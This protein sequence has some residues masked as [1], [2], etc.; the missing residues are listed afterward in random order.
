MLRKKKNGRVKKAGFK[1]TRRLKKR[2]V[3][4]KTGKFKKKLRIGKKKKPGIVRG[5][6]RKGKRAGLKAGR[7]RRRGLKSRRFA[8]RP[9]RA[10]E[11][12][13]DRSGGYDAGFDQGY[14]EGFREGFNKGLED[15]ALEYDQRKPAV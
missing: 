15:G 7:K 11:G 13:I 12:V 14:K 5:K 3:L 2:S 10:S 8:G 6:L 1:G 9:N 4:K